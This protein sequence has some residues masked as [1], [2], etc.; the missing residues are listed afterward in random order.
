MINGFKVYLDSFNHLF[1]HH[2]SVI[3]VSFGSCHLIRPATKA[4]SSDSTPT[5]KCTPTVHAH[6][7]VGVLFDDRAF[8]AGLDRTFTFQDKYKKLW[9]NTSSRS[10]I[11]VTIYSSSLVRPWLEPP[12]RGASIYG[13]RSRV[14]LIS[15]K[16]RLNTFFQRFKK[17]RKSVAKREQISSELE[18]CTSPFR[19]L[20]RCE[21]ASE[22]TKM[23]GSTVTVA[24]Q[25]G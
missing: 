11:N 12:R 1:Y 8:V 18:R 13:L 7:E 17:R 22:K 19:S 10:E 25:C 6:F 23:S 4:R 20:L 16:L 5:S 21:I 15:L 3:A 9:R 14:C 24:T 2:E